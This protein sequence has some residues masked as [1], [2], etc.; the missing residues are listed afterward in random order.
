MAQ[1]GVNV[2]KNA[3]LCGNL[4]LDKISCRSASLTSQK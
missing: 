4:P 3:T 2:H 1:T